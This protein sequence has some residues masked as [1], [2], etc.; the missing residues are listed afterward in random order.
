MNA[1]ATARATVFVVDDDDA[2]RD[3]LKLLLET[4]GMRVE[5]YASAA[6]FL[7]AFTEERGGC[8]VLD[9]K[10]PG[11]SGLELQQLLV[12]R[13]STLPVIFLTGHGD[14]PMSVR[15]FKAGAA[16]FLEKPIDQGALL[17][18]VRDALGNDAARRARDA[19]RRAAN[20]RLDRLTPREREV[21]ARVVAGRTSKEIARELGVSPR[22]VEVHRAR[23][24]E[25]VRVESLPQLVT[26]VAAAGLLE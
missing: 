15:A 13:G 10:M 9:V 8:L 24:M 1:S 11:M 21:L 4:S 5:D 3:A 25:K 2:V 23:I 22:T 6:Q 26:A 7:D 18:R 19:E 16:D 12:E 17:E 14:V 20:A